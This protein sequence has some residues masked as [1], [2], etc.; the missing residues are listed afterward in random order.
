MTRIIKNISLIMLC[1][2]ISYAQDDFSFDE[3]FSFEDD[4]PVTFN[5]TRVISG[6]SVE[7]LPPQTFEMRIE[8]RF[9]DIAG[10]NGGY[11]TMFGFDNVSDMRIALE[12]GVNEDLM[13]GFG[14][15]KGTSQP[16]RSLLDG[17]VKYKVLSQAKEQAPV[18]LTAVGGA[19]FTYQEASSD[20]SSI[21]HFPET[22][23]RLSYYTQLNIARRFGKILSVC[24]MPTF[25]HRNYVAADDVNS[26]LSLGTAIRVRLSKKFFLLAEYY[27]CI[28]EG[29]FR[30]NGYNNSLGLAL[31]WSTFGH[32]FTINFTNSK[33]LGETQFIPYTFENWSD[34]Q[35]RLGFC[36]SRQF[37]IKK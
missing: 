4:N 1:V 9:G 23:H 2:N 19:S 10:S 22:T 20:I 17:F 3:D 35:F 34:G 36:V 30:K 16:Y 12:Y 15:C 11:Q 27:H 7:V 33:G 28:N 26:L 37:A 8:H 18:S 32:N 25:V 29:D 24:L 13:L 6:H 5:S 31:E 21:S 14:R